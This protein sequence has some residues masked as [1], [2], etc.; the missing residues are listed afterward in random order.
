MVP[1]CYEITSM[2]RMGAWLTYNKTLPA[3]TAFQTVQQLRHC[4]L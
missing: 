4:N 2:V 3:M 1:V